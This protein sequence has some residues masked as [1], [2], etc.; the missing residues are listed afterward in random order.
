MGTLPGVINQMSI[1]SEFDTAIQPFV[2]S[3]DR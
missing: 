1:M 2:Q 3:V